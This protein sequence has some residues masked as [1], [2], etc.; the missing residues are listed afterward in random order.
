MYVWVCSVKHYEKYTTLYSVIVLWIDLSVTFCCVAAIHVIILFSLNINSGTLSP[1]KE[2][3]RDRTTIMFSF[4]LYTGVLTMTARQ[5][6]PP[7]PQTRA[8]QVVNNSNACFDW[9]G[10]NNTVPGDAH[11]GS[12]NRTGVVATDWRVCEALCANAPRCRSWAW[13]GSP[14]ITD[15]TDPSV[16]GNGM[17]SWRSDC[18]WLGVNQRNRVSG[19]KGQTPPAPIN[20]NPVAVPTPEQLEW[21]DLE[22]Q[23]LVFVIL[24]I[25]A[26]AFVSQAP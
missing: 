6:C 24:K 26:F 2:N 5:R 20:T 8:M 4:Y 3:G 17:C 14:K 11:T 25:V 21:M 23:I 19:F 1:E 12:C 9:E 7:M 18:V 16:R 13:G 22:V 10:C 15:P